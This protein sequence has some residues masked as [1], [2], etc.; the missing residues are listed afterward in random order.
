VG[1]LLA[2]VVGRIHDDAGDPPG[3]VIET[4]GPVA[5]RSGTSVWQRP[6]FDFGLTGPERG[7]TGGKVLIIGPGHTTPEDVTGFHVIHSPTR[8]VNI[9]YRIIDRSEKDKIAPLNKVYS[10]EDRANPP[11][12]RILS[13]TEDYTQS[14]PRGLA[15]WEAVN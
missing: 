15:Y 2:L 9:G 6:L 4:S 13:A 8:F 11:T 14:Q 7:A 3:S 12:I 5:R 10:Y 1:L